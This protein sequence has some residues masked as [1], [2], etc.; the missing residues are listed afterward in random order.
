MAAKIYTIPQ[1]VLVVI[2]TPA[3]AVLLIKR[4]DAEDFWHA[5]TGAKYRRAAQPRVTP[6]RGARGETRRAR[7][8]P[9][10]GV[11]WGVPAAERVVEF[12]GVAPH[13]RAILQQPL[14]ALGEIHFAA[15]CR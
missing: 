12:R 1:S 7:G 10:G 4:A 6:G 5:V 14:A 2:Y 3:L 13:M 15:P 8:G 9:V 11:P